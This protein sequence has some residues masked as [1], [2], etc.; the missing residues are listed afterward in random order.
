MSDQMA[1]MHADHRLTVAEVL[2]LL[3]ADGIVAKPEADAL[4]AE[5]RLKRLTAHP[6]VIVAD[7]K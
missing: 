1:N 2:G 3:V 6:L 4:V 7:Q 5:F